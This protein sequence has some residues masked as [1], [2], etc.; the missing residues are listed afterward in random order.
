MARHWQP[1][2]SLKEFAKLE[3]V[4]LDAEALYGSDATQWQ[5]LSQL[6]PSCIKGIDLATPAPGWLDYPLDDFHP[7][8]LMEDITVEPTVLPSLQV[9]ATSRIARRI[10]KGL[11]A[12]GVEVHRYH[13]I[14]YDIS[15][16]AESW[17]AWDGE[18]WNTRPRMSDLLR[19]AGK[20]AQNRLQT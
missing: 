16:E 4:R 12:R 20:K 9:L 11:E 18:Q 17:S 6:I 10:M 19:A 14:T 5:P 1:L 3:Y 8:I 15:E 13:P 7:Y 2:G